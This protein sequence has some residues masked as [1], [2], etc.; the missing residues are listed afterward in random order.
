MLQDIVQYLKT[1]SANNFVIYFDM[2]VML[3]IWLG[4]SRWHISSTN[5]V[6]AHNLLGSTRQVA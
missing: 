4:A 2:P 5:L 1:A 3:S 6:L